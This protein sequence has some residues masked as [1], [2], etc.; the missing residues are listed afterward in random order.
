[1]KRKAGKLVVITM[2]IGVLS[3]L[4]GCSYLVSDIDRTKKEVEEYNTLVE[5]TVNA[6]TVIR[7]VAETNNRGILR[8]VTTD[9]EFSFVED[10]ETKELTDKEKEAFKHPTVIY[11]KYFTSLGADAVREVLVISGK[12]H[13]MF[14][15]AVWNQEQIV[16]LDRK[17]VEQ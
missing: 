10:L 17:V 13:R 11:D 8:Y 6:Y 16:Y 14:V 4:S 3:L 7:K 9:K 15:T 12:K 5:D 2:L 1:M